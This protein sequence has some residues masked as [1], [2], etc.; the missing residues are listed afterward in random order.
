MRC[1]SSFRL[2]SGIEASSWA[3]KTQ[4]WNITAGKRLWLPELRAKPPP[5]QVVLASPKST[6]GRRPNEKRLELLSCHHH[7]LCR[8]RRVTSGRIAERDR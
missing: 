8:W 7:R 6:A 3:L 4:T 1:S 5:D 2:F